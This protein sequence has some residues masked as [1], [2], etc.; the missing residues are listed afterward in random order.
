MM[1]KTPIAEASVTMAF[2]YSLKFDT[3]WR[4]SSMA[5][6][7]AILSSSLPYCWM[8]DVVR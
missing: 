3:F 2:E 7:I 5:S 8:W 6:N 1:I 4:M